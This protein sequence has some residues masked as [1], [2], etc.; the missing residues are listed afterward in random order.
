MKVKTQIR[1]AGVFALAT[2]LWIILPDWRSH[3]F[4][5]Y[6]LGEF[7]ET[8]GVAVVASGMLFELVLFAQFVSAIALF[9]Y[10][11]WAW[12]LVLITLSVQV[13]LTTL[14]ALCLAILPFVSEP[15]EPACVEPGCIVVTISLWPSYFRAGIN[16]VTVLILFSSGV[17]SYFLKQSTELHNQTLHD[18]VDSC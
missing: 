6:C 14:N 10:R 12:F 15:V 1:I 4:V 18:A 8:V 17:R 7:V 5:F 16:A 13:L 11:R 2:V 3:L 9:S